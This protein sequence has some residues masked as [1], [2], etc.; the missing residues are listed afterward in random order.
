[1]KCSQF[2]HLHMTIDAYFLSGEYYLACI[3]YY[4]QLRGPVTLTHI[5]EHLTTDL[6]VS[7]PL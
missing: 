7:L 1:M 6:H 3:C 2:I 5:A 4:G